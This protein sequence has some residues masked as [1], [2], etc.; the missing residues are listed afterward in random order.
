MKKRFREVFVV[1][2][3]YSGFGWV[4]LFAYQS[5][6]K[7]HEMLRELSSGDL[8]SHRLLSRKEQI[9]GNENM[10]ARERQNR[11]SMNDLVPD[12]LSQHWSQSDTKGMIALSAFN[13]RLR[14]TQKKKFHEIQKIFIDRGIVIDQQEF[15]TLIQE[16]EEYKLQ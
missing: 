4:D 13:R 15:E 3:N 12:S 14:R 5:I 2:G 7:A 8:G 11:E 1:Q 10:S 6:N 16:L 9:V